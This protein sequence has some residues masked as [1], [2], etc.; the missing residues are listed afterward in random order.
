MLGG[1]RKVRQAEARGLHY[2]QCTREYAQRTKTIKIGGWRIVGDDKVHPSQTLDHAFR[3][4]TD[5]N[6]TSLSALIISYFQSL[7]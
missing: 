4:R 6:L 2:P 3:F 1:V 5:D 7:P